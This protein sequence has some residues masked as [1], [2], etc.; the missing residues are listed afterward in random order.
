MDATLTPIAT[1]IYQTY[2]SPLHRLIDKAEQIIQDYWAENPDL[3]QIVQLKNQQAAA[4]ESPQKPALD[5]TQLPA[6]VFDPLNWPHF[7]LK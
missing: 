5:K 2:S 3:Y 6:V 1:A 7:S 4:N